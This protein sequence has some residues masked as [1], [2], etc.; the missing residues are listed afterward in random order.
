M[1]GCGGQCTGVLAGLVRGMTVIPATVH[2][3]EERT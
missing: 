2:T 3:R 1:R